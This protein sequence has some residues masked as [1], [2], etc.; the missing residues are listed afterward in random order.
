MTAPV[1]KTEDRGA[2]LRGT[3]E[4]QRSALNK[5]AH[6][7]IPAASLT[8]AKEIVL[9][10]LGALRANKMR[11]F[12][13][14]LGIVIGVAAVIAMVAIGKGAQNSISERIAS[15]GTTLLTVRPGSRRGFGVATE[16][17]EK[18][19]I[20]DAEALERRGTYFAA[21]GA[22]MNKRLLLQYGSL[23]AQTQVTASKPNWL[24]T[25]K[26]SLAGGRF[27]TD[28]EEEGSR[29]VAVLGPAERESIGLESPE[30]I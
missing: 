22:E 8:L 20:K 29:R 3:G 17:N 15:L 21:V 27:F 25:R 10:A 4:P 1:Q 18:L 6:G 2:R 14:M 11:S 23:N 12:L 24:D 26:V 7:E 19:T 5:A 30:R 9:V 28:Q 16:S 13:T